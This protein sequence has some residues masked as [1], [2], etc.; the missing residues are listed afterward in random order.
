MARI[1][2]LTATGPAK[3]EPRDK[4]ISI[5]ACG[6]SKTFPFCDGAH[7]TTAKL[8][9]PGRLYQYDPTTFAVVRDEIDPQAG[10]ISNQTQCETHLPPRPIT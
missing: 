1:V 10:E 8:E 3:I 2:R 7:K 9:Q 5:C 6:L 4:P